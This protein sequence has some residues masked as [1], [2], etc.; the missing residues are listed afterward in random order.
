MPSC[1]MRGIAA[2]SASQALSAR[3]PVSVSSCGRRG[4][5]PPLH[6]HERD[7]ETFY[8]IDGE[9][10]LFVGGQ[11]L[12]LGAG[13][14]ALAPRAVPHA[15][16]VESEEARWLLVTTPAGFES[17]VRE[18]AEPAP[19][20]ELPPAGRPQDPAVLAQAAAK[21]GI[22]I[23]GSLRHIA[24]AVSL[25]PGHLTTVV[26]RKTGWTVQEWIAERRMAQARRLLV[27]TDLTVAEVG[28]RVGYADPVYFARYFRRAHAS[29]PLRW[30]R[31]GRA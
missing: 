16:R 8:V 11:Q 3:R 27:E 4:D 21:I 9:L 6:V 29:T 17:F 28:R 30:R 31:A 13:Q 10:S 24:D 12:I 5:M 15:Y 14:A 22:E 20:D 1:W 2:G 26:R 18:V 23:L 7:D 19:A 25:S